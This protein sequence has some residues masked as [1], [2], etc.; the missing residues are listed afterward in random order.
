MRM[1]QGARII[2]ESWLHA[3]PEDVLHFIT[4]ETKLEEARAFS[5]A[6]CRAGAIPK[7]TVLPADSVQA[8]DSIEQKREI[9]S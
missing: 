2:V 1:E 6:A 3:Q 8:G 7:L 9:M 5:E 4:D